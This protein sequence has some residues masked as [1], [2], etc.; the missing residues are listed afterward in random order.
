ME[1]SQDKR[2][3]YS[4]TSTFTHRLLNFVYGKIFAVGKDNLMILCICNRFCGSP[5]NRIHFTSY[6]RR[7]MADYFFEKARNMI[8]DQFDV[9]GK[10]LENV[11][12]INIL[13]RYMHANFKHKEGDEFIA[14]AYQICLD[15]ANKFKNP[16][17]NPSYKYQVDYALFT[18]HITITMSL[19]GLLNG[20][21]DR[22]TDESSHL[23]LNGSL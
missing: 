17:Q 19:R 9:P 12:S 18:R 2:F 1:Y 3:C 14:I 11:M 5:C 13:G 6:D 8:L 22:P 4:S 20:L 7:A 21:F 10:K 15:L 23:T 16:P